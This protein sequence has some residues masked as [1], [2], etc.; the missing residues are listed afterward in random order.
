MIIFFSNQAAKEIRAIRDELTGIRLATERIATA[1]EKQPED[2]EPT[3]I[4][5]H[6]DVP[7]QET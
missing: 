1:L 2:R 5:W 4:T 6:T 7:E 3:S